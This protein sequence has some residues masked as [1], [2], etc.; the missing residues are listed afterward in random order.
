M[1]T[2]PLTPAQAGDLA[3]QFHDIAVTIGSYR[4]KNVGTFS[5]EEQYQLQNQQMQCLQYSNS[6]IT[7]GLTLEMTNLSATLQQIKQATT[8]AQQAIA[9]VGAVDKVLQIVTAVAVLGA[10]IASMNP[11]A[12]ASGAQGVLT[13]IVGGAAGTGAATAGAGTGAG[14]AGAGS[15]PASGE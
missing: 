10:S 3:Q 12:I 15:G 6:F 5:A 2:Q 14:I 9:N 13:S 11:A 8:Q 7:A 1:A 4:L